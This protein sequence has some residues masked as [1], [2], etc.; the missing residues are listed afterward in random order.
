MKLSIYNCG[1]KFFRLVGRLVDSR[2][3]RILSSVQNGT[4]CGL[5]RGPTRREPT[6]WGGGLS[7]WTRR[8]VGPVNERSFLFAVS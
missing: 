8:S 7:L 2:Y 5:R 3:H 6:K 1:D 4:G